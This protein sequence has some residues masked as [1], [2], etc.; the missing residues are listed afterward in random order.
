MRERYRQ[1]TDGRATAY[2]EREREFTLAKNPQ[3]KKGDF[4]IF[5]DGGRR[6]LG[7]LYFQNFKGRKVHK[8]PNASLCRISW[9]SVKLLLLWRFFDFKDGAVRH[10]GFLK[11]LIRSL[12]ADRVERINMRLRAKF[13]RV[14]VHHRAK[15]RGDKLNRC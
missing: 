6:H 4:S 15:F 8:G 13:Q 10:L 2:S 9:P 12:T 7:F 3:D 5:Q 1:T 11:C 14:T